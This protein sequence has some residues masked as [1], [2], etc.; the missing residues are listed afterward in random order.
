M[1]Y[2]EVGQMSGAY[3][4]TRYVGDTLFAD[5]LCQRVSYTAYYYNEVLQSDQVLGYGAFYTISHPGIVY[6]WAQGRFDTLY[7]FAANPGDHWRMPS[8]SELYDDLQVN[9]LDTGHAAI[10]GQELSY[11]VV[12]VTVPSDGYVFIPR[13][14]IYERMGPLFMYCIWVETL[15]TD[16]GYYDL[17]CYS[18]DAMTY[19]RV[20]GCCDM[21]LGIATQ[22]QR[23]AVTAYPN[24]AYDRLWLDGPDMEG[25]LRVAVY[26]A[27]GGVVLTEFMHPQAGLDVSKLAPGVYTVVA[28]TRDGHDLR[29]RWV[30]G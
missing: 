10:D 20:E 1:W 11:Q 29:V 28:P 6:M 17:R 22:Q 7:H 23:S 9:V 12:Q 24:P 8:A 4:E 19:T 16:G 5:S 15:R 2:H 14:T 3:V 13:D 30:K 25:P 18:D 21:G 27:R 26:D